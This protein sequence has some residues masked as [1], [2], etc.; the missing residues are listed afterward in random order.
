MP[1]DACLMQVAFDPTKYVISAIFI[2]IAAASLFSMRRFRIPNKGKIALIY[3]HL[4]SLFMP[5]SVF[6]ANE[7][8]GMMCL[9]CFENPAGIAVLALPSAML[10]SAAA[11]FVVIPAYFFASG[12]NVKINGTRITKFISRHS[13]LLNIRAPKVVAVN[14]PKPF[15]LSFRTFR[16]AIVLSVGLMDILHKKEL[17]AVLLHELAHLKNRASLF[18]LSAFLMSFSPFSVFKSFNNE[19]NMEEFEADSLVISVQRTNKYLLSAKRKIANYRR[20]YGY[21]QKK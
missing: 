13:R 21:A 14:S 16:S 5:V 17:E 6:A 3:I 12:R 9:P 18:K 2:V 15:A 1:V 4:T 7:A 10:F 19:L 8:C 11:G 20:A